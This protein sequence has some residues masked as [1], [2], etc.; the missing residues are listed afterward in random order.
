[1]DFALLE[2]AMG[3]ERGQAA[4]VGDSIKESFEIKVYVIFICSLL[5]S[6]GMVLHQLE[7]ICL[8][9]AARAEAVLTVI[10]QAVSLQVTVDSVVHLSLKHPAQGA[11]NSNGPVSRRVRDQTEVRQTRSDSGQTKVRKRSDR[12]YSM[13]DRGQTDIQQRSYNFRQKSDRGQPEVRQMS[14][15]GNK[16]VT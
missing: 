10:N 16:E 6:L 15:K 3:V 7:Q 2:D 9:R 8:T 13:S 11:G 4:L 1:M 14:V 5:C 12:G